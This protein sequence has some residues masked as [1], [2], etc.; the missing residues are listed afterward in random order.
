MNNS[1]DCVIIGGGLAGLSAALRLTNEGKKVAVLEKHHMPG[2]YATNFK[3]KDDAGNFYT[4][5]VALHGIGGLR[6]GEALHYVLDQKLDLLNALTLLEKPET[7]TILTQ[8]GE[9]NDIPS[10]F[11]TYK[12]YLISKYPKEQLGI[13]KLFAFLMEVKEDMLEVTCTE[14]RMPKHH[15]YLQSV[16]LYDFLKT[17]VSSEAF[18]EEFSFLWLYYG[19]PPK[20]L[21]ALYYILPWISY[22]IGGT[23][24]IQGGAGKLSDTLRDAIEA[25]G[26]SVYLL[27]EVTSINLN[28][29][30]I[31]SVTTKKGITFTAEHFIIACDPNYILGLIKDSSTSI[32]DYKDQLADLKNGISLSQIYIG[33]DC[34]SQELGM[35]K[36]DYFIQVADHEKTY[37]AILNGD[38]D[39]MSFGLTCYDILD[40]TLNNQSQGVICIVIGDLMKNW[41]EYKSE[42][43]KE[44]KQKL[45]NLLIA[46]VEKTFPHIKEHIK[47][48]EVGTPHTMKRYT[49]NTEGSVYGWAQNVGQGGFDRLSFKTPFTN[50]LLAGAW[51]SPGGG[52]EGAILSGVICAD[53]L[54]RQMHTTPQT[55]TSTTSMPPMSLNA[56]MA[57]MIANLNPKK[58]KDL[59]LVFH[60]C[61]DNCHNYYIQIKNK[62]GKLLKHK[63]SHIDLSVYTSYSTWYQIAFE[64][65]SGADAL[66]DG[67]IKLEGSID[68][69]M[70][71]PELFNTDS[72]SNNL[73]D[74]LATPAS[75]LPSVLWVNLALV[76]W[77]IY[78]S[79]G[80][81]LNPLYLCLITLCY[82]LGFIH[83]IKPRGYKVL[84][85]LESIGLLTFTCYGIFTTTFIDLNPLFVNYSVDVVL[86]ISF[87]F[88][89]LIHKPLTAPYACIEYP[90]SMTKT[91]LFT[92][93]NCTLTLMWAIIF[94]LKFIIDIIIPSPFNYLSY[95][96][97]VIGV[98]LSYYYPKK[99]LH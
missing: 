73:S 49:N 32:Q 46:Q 2:G 78:W 13:E 30:K 45:A 97:I 81:F 64:G 24:Y 61:F 5:D 99:K 84:T 15:H 85:G 92:S 57:G 98:I 38:Y 94:S 79:M 33:L 10:H 9:E 93:I 89:V 39:K 74:D 23:F 14:N 42:A 8:D 50:T 56:F 27:S 96:F 75:K 76:P 22:H 90:K 43:Y 68:T 65:K 55:N 16:T 66:F 20:Q 58:A 47:V 88:S 31:Q 3:R 18:I 40:P 52:F 25:K 26:S 59:D 11:E 67:E 35:T 41:P 87:F 86:I 28:Q 63:P 4:F 21:N 29:D 80:D 91:K 71:I 36:G 6:K 7:A 53:R 95:L 19:L 62:K 77:I 44:Q 72:L 83:F 60:F 17:Y 12:N 51:V 82:T 34:P 37:E 1:Y 54:L 69:F 70:L 48:L